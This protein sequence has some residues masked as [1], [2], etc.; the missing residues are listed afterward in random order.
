[1]KI[2]Y[3]TEVNLDIPSG[4]LF[5]MNAQID[6]WKKCGHDVYVVS[7][8]CQI[9]TGGKECLTKSAAG[10]F[11]FIHP[12]VRTTKNIALFNLGNKILSAGRYKNY[13]QSI[14]PDI[15]YLREMIAY[16]GVGRLLN[17]HKVIIENNTLLSEEVKMGS[18]SLLKMYQLFQHQI[19]D[20]VDG[21]IGVTNE[22]SSHYKHFK[23][24]VTTI[25]NGIKLEHTNTTITPSN[26]RAQLI[27]VGSPNMTWHGMDKFQRMAELIP[28]ADFHLVGEDVPNNNLSN[29][30]SHGYLEKDDL[31]QLY[32]KIDVA[33]G[34]LALH[35]KKMY[36]AC[37]LKVRQYASLGIPLIIA[38]N[39]TDFSGQNFVLQ[40][41]N[42][43]DNIYNHVS[44]I[45]AFVRNWKGKRVS[46]SAIEPLI[47]STAKENQRLAFFTHIIN[48]RN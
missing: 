34:T 35:R 42:A 19:N 9:T 40:L 36:E 26:V 15:I 43:E 41:P 6:E 22:I 38:Y 11:I 4:V 17:K 31:M 10:A 21:F 24:P 14:N 23:K 30:F 46:L 7:I 12:F 37:P 18:R 20:N 39:D 3:I 13:I 48:Q 2:I 33:V 29:F 27:L 16:P 47:S 25:T 28:E 32:T 44:E 5:K 1:M 8:P 45:K